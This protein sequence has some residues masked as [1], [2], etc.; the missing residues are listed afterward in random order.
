MKGMPIAYAQAPKDWFRIQAAAVAEDESTSADVYIY[1][2]IGET[3]W[4]GGVSAKKFAEQI[5]ALDVD[6]IRLFLNSPG[7]AAWEGVTIMNSLRRHRARVEVTVDGMAASAASLIAMAGDHITM[8]RGSMLMI[9]DAWGFAIGNAT[10]MQ[11]TAA[12]LDKLSA[13]YADSYAARAGKDRDHWRALMKAETWFSAEEAVTAGLADEWVDGPEDASDAAARFD[14]SKFGFAYAGRSH[15]PAPPVGASQTPVSSE[16]GEPIRKENVVAYDDLKA[17][18]AK[19][20]GVTDAEAS[21]DTLLAAVDQALAEQAE[22]PTE[23]AALPE[24]VVAID[25][26]VLADLQAKAAQGVEA[27]KSQT[28]TR[29]EGI[30]AKALEDGRIAPASKDTWA[31][32]LERDEEGTVKA[33][34]SLVKNAIPVEEIGHADVNA[35]EDEALAAAAGWADDTKEA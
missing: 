35:S 22:T 25:S 11:E 12:I 23:T 15:A 20:L 18:L 21:D 9:H 10:D 33:L 29:R 1:D 3:W 5:N 34:D 24:G 31:T 17:G 2:Q 4:G 14:L 7:G 28:E 6:T 8:N 27:L 13:S 32:L 30:L 16:P 26:A 19:R